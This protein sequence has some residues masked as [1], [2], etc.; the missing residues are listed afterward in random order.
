MAACM[1]I[2][3]GDGKGKTTAAVGLS[4]RFAGS[5]GRVLFCQFMKNHS[6]GER[7]SLAM[8]PNITVYEGYAMPKFS[9]QMTESEREK[10]AQA[11]SWQ[12]ADIAKKS[13]HYGLVV[14]DEICTCIS[15]GLL[16]A[17][18]VLSFAENRPPETELVLTG[19]DPDSRL[20]ALADYVSEI[21]CQKH[22]YQKG[23]AARKGIE[24]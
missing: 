20:L 24:F 11:Y 21:V 8:I 1:H 7:A 18:E 6:S 9:F 2:Y 19:R 14:L 4:V 17:E 16:S 5:G 23:V 10:A 22:P 13:P 3:C 15:C 12:L